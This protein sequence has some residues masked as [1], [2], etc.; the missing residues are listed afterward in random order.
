VASIQGTT[1]FGL[2]YQLDYWSNSFGCA[3]ISTEFHLL[4]SHDTYKKTFVRLSM[5]QQ[6][7]VLISKV[8]Q[9]LVNG[10]SAFEMF[11]LDERALNENKK[12]YLRVILK[13]HP[14]RAAHLVAVSN[15]WGQSNM[16]GKFY[17][18]HIKL[19]RKCL[20]DFAKAEDGDQFFHDKKFVQYPNGSVHLH[21]EL[22]SKPK[23][24]YRPSEV[25]AAPVTMIASAANLP[26]ELVGGGGREPMDL[27][28]CAGLGDPSF[29]CERSFMQTKGGSISPS[30]PQVYNHGDRQQFAAAG[31]GLPKVNGSPFQEHKR[32]LQYL[33]SLSTQYNSTPQKSNLKS[34]PGSASLFTPNAKPPCSTPKT[35]SPAQGAWMYEQSPEEAK[36]AALQ[37][38]TYAKNQAADDDSIATTVFE[39]ES[40]LTEAYTEYLKKQAAPNL[41]VVTP[42]SEFHDADSDL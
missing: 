39:E 4:S 28:Q 33:Q 9:C 19:P 7:L 21:V 24:G 11:L 14:K 38:A 16:S 32:Y 2:P 10:S 34:P 22:L 40:V 13:H 12:V 3:R 27:S 5:D 36:R 20:H 23:D 26:R 17:E 35:S 1:S 31:S 18:H 30:S 8:N 6:H 41:Q 42:D 25:T 29:T 37:K 15:T